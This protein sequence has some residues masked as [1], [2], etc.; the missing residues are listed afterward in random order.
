[1]ISTDSDSERLSSELASFFQQAT[2]P[3]NK[4]ALFDTTKVTKDEQG[5]KELMVR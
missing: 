3:P 5:V 2:A 4:L 1:M